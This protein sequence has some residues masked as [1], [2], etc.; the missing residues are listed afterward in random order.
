[1][2]LPPPAPLGPQ[3]TAALACLAGS[4]PATLLREVQGVGF[5]PVLF[6]R[7]ASEVGGA[8]AGPAEMLTVTVRSLEKAGGCAVWGAGCAVRT[9]EEALLFATAGF[10]WFT[11]E[12]S[13]LVN[14]RANS[15]TLDELDA[16]IVALEDAGCYRANWHA[17]YIDREWRT[18]SGASLRLE[19]AVLARAAV[20]FGPA[21]AHADQVHE[22]IRTVWSGRGAPP[23]IELN[24]SARRAALSAPEFLFLALESWRRG[25]QPAVIAA[26]LGSAWQPGAEF[27][28]DISALLGP[29]DEIAA[30]AGPTKV[31]VHFASG[32]PGLIAAAHSR[33]NTRLHLNLEELTWLDWLGAMAEQRPAAFLEW[34]HAA[35]EIFPLA[36]A[37]LPLAITEE[38]THALPQ[39]A[40][41]ELRD[42]FL[43]HV[44]GRQLLLST[45]DAVLRMRGGAGL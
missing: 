38:H 29:F 34:L 2:D 12:L 5:Q 19:D 31:G 25:L 36:A 13:S 18:A 20:K 43:G 1:M 24:C 7:L 35:Q 21:L 4:V 32:K 30:L 28:G 33:F 17:D 23:D 10:T 26:A 37:D 14:D 22:A 45:F 15:M 27:A 9:A 42:T 41:A 8:G 6:H 40:E 39:V 16:T 44:Q 3:P 11:V